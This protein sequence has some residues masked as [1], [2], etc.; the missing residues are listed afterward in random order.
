M[1]RLPLLLLN[2]RHTL[3]KGRHK[4]IMKKLLKKPGLRNRA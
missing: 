3:Y 1:N 4:K 2:G